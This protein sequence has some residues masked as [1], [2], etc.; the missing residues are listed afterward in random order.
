MVA[1]LLAMSLAGATALN[2]D[3]AKDSAPQLGSLFER[4]EVVTLP[5]LMCLLAVSALHYVATAFAA[6]AAS[7]VR[8]PF[9]ELVATQLA[10]SAAN[11]LTPSGIGGAT[12]TGRYFIRRGR[13]DPSAAAA[14]VSALALLGA[15]ADVLAF[16][17]V[18]AV[19][20][21]AGLAGAR[22]EAPLLLQKI[23]GLFPLPTG[24]WRWA[25]M[26]LAVLVAT[27]GWLVGK[28]TGAIVERVRGALRTYRGSLAAL[29]SHPA[30]LAA[31]MTASAGTTLLLATGFAAAA[32]LGTGGLPRSAFCA[33]MIGY[34]LAAAAGNA[35]PTPGGIGTADA[36]LTGVL[37]A[38]H[39]PAA[40][41]L[42]TVL[43]FRLISFWS[44]AVIGLC[45]L[46]PLRRRGAL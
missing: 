31:L 13:L 21:V 30:R 18:V 34:M 14:A 41:A 2:Q 4:I 8:L 7:G 15:V 40:D 39:M 46:A 1:I 35:L 23:V 33:L 22:S 3:L 19:G 6:R 5:V 38:A 44:P 27:L 20:S 12:V 43:A 45:L 17:A 11:R 25:V 24:W 36:A 9:G 29:L 37:L 10:A 42:A 16:G 32:T 26:T 28:R